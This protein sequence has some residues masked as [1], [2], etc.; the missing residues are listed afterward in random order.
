M[1][2][3]GPCKH[4]ERTSASSGLVKGSRAVA[5]EPK[6]LCSRHQHT[7][8]TICISTLTKWLV[9]ERAGKKKTLEKKKSIPPWV[10]WSPKNST[11]SHVPIWCWETKGL[12]CSN[13]HDLRDRCICVLKT[14][15]RTS[16]IHSKLC[17]HF[18]SLLI[19]AGF[20]TLSVLNF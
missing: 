12:L 13:C 7:K 15:L 2:K 1:F 6:S 5:L 9:R 14:R 10:V 18:W 3:F 20:E 19:Q 11:Y 8:V 4:T 16:N 17:R